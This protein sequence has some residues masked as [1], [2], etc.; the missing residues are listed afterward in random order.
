MTN[1]MP[2]AVPT[3]RMTS[4]PTRPWSML[5]PAK[6]DAM[7]VAKGLIVEPSTPIPQPRRSSEAPTMV[8]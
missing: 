5:V 7:P 4:R 2:M 3:T 1:Q 8:S 6:P